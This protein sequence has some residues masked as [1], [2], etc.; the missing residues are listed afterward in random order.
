MTS[1]NQWN[2]CLKLYNKYSEEYKIQAGKFDKKK[3][4]IEKNMGQCLK[5]AIEKFKRFIEQFK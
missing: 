4:Q 1:S 5:Q 2:L 3:F